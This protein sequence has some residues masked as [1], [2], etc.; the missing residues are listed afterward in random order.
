M[1]QIKNTTS[2]C[3]DSQIIEE[4][5]IES[6]S[7]SSFNPRYGK[8]THTLFD[9]N[10]ETFI[11]TADNRSDP[12]IVTI[13]LVRPIFVYSIILVNRHGRNL[14]IDNAAI[15]LVDSNN[16]TTAC[17]LVKLKT[18]NDQ[19]VVHVKCKNP[20]IKSEQVVVT[21]D[22]I[23]MSINIAELRICSTNEPSK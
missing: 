4:S 9:N 14:R 19:E 1:L 21:K 20:H 17:G 5:D 8:N 15:K 6:V 2:E 7:M 22:P 10:F 16:E 23:Y 11:H 13:N 3:E 18:E 12:G